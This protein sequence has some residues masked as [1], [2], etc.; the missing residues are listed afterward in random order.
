MNFKRFVS[1]IFILMLVMA[2][3][4]L[5]AQCPNCRA[6]VESGLKSGATKVGSGLNSGILYLLALPYVLVSVIGFFWYRNYRA[7]K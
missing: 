6:A 7:R 4:D 1:F 3:S 2:S 5:F